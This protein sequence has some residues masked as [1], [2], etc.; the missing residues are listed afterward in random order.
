MPKRARVAIVNND[1]KLNAIMANAVYVTN[2]ADDLTVQIQT[3]TDRYRQLA[4][5]ATDIRNNLRTYR[6]S[7]LTTRQALANIEGALKL[8]Q[9]Q[10]DA[11]QALL[12][13]RQNFAAR[14]AVNAAKGQR[15]D[16]TCYLHFV[17]VGLGDC[18]A[19]ST[20][21]G[22]TIM[23]DCGTDSLSD[24]ILDPDYDPSTNIG[25]DTYI[26]NTIKGKTF[27]NTGKNIDL[28]FLTHPDADHHNKLKTVLGPV[29]AK[30]GLVYYGGAD[31]IEDYAGGT[32]AYL[33]QAAGT[34]ASLFR[35]VTLSEGAFLDKNKQVVVTRAINGNPVSKTAGQAGQ[36]G[37]EFLDPATGAMVVYYEQTAKSNFR[38][39][40]LAGNVV[41]AWA[42]GTYALLESPLKDARE[43]KLDSTPANRRGLMVL[44]ECF[45]ARILICGDGTTVTEKFVVNQFPNVLNGVTILRM[46]HHGSPTSSGQ[47]FLNAL[48]GLTRAVVSTGGENTVLHFLPKQRVLALYGALPSGAKKHNIYSFESGDQ[49]SQVYLSNITAWLY[50]TG[51]ND[52]IAF[53]ISQS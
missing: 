12:V 21:S 18:T 44:V 47:F 34:A 7:G 53:P 16:G 23:I 29:R 43:M 1:D 38:I 26:A 42:D 4:A 14:V 24:V 45:G 35:R 8:I 10:I 51:S 37:D 41:G 9:G 17:N 6:F 22:R 39:S 32:S 28:L 48:G 33:K 31:K 20:P 50:A 49:K 11:K 3:L 2:P 13:K 15:G 30:I 36:L 19:I 52:T 5:G 27:L 46:G 40:L 25:A